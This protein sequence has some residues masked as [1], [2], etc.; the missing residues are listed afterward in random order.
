MNIMKNYIT[1]FPTDP[2]PQRQ[3]GNRY[4][5]HKGNVDI[6]CSSLDRVFNKARLF[7]VPEKSII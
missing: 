2:Q 6:N 7:W 3:I 5:Y 1:S 4:I